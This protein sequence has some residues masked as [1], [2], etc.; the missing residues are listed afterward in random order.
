MKTSTTAR[1]P[2][3]GGEAA[4]L[5][6][7]GRVVRAGCSSHCM[8]NCMLRLHVRDGCANVLTR[9][10]A[11]PGGAFCSNTALVQVEKATREAEAGGLNA[12]AR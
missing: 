11:S 3:A 9:D 7:S 6:G 12:T 4:R 5:P 8:G 1:E 10:K 2:E